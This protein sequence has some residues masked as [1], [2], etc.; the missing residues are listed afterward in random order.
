[1]KFHRL[2]D[3]LR[4]WWRYPQPSWL[5]RQ[6][7]GQYTDVVD[8]EFTALRLASEE[9]AQYVLRNM[10]TVPNFETDYDLHEWVV[11]TQ[12]SGD[13]PLHSQVLEFGVATGRTLNHFARLMPNKHIHGFDSFQGLPEDWTSRMPRGFFKRRQYPKVAENTYLYVGWFDATLPMW[14]VRY[15]DSP[16]LLLHIDCDLYS[17]T[18]TVLTELRENIV[19]GTVII[20]DEYMNYPGW[21]QDEF[22]AWKEFVRDYDIQYEYIGRVSRHQQVA[23]RVTA[24]LTDK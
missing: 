24:V 23:V 12:L 17:S 10:R 18:K 15:A 20:F 9:S 7:V 16:I 2:L 4:Q 1:M 3:R 14:K 5:Q 6:L 19:V 8:T 21:Q 11:N 13:M 22:R